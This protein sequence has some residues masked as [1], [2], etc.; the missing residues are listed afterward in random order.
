VK[1]ISVRNSEGWL[2]GKYRVSKDI[3]LTH[4][5]TLKT[6]LELPED[7]FYIESLTQKVDVGSWI[8]KGSEVVPYYRPEEA[9]GIASKFIRS[10]WKVENLSEK[11]E[12]LCE[13]L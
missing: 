5:P 4:A 9:D 3:I 2:V 10:D 1:I 12:E 7:D 8:A 11:E 13:K 6:T